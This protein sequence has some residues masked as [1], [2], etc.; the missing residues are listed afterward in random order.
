MNIRNDLQQNVAFAN[1]GDPVQCAAGVTVGRRLVP[2]TRTS[3]TGC[4]GR[5]S[6]SA[7][8]QSAALSR[9]AALSHDALIKPDDLWRS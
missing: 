8:S 9:G 7:V 3:A 6:R 5:S 4:L 2:G 1:R